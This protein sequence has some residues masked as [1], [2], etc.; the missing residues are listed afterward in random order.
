MLFFYVL[1]F[2][3]IGYVIWRYTAASNS[4]VQQP[5]ENTSATEETNSTTAVESSVQE[6]AK[7]GC[8]RSSNGLCVGLHLLS[9]EEW[10]AQQAEVAAPAKK[11]STK[12]KSTTTTR[13]KKSS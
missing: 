5:V 7:C 12:A 3:A 9:D 4:P 13:K 10:K 11:K 8:G 1:I 2:V 6:P